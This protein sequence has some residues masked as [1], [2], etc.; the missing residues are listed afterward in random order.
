MP[1]AASKNNVAAIQVF[2]PRGILL[3]LDPTCSLEQV[4]PNLNP[5]LFDPL[6]QIENACRWVSGVMLTASNLPPKEHRIG[7]A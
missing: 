4:M 5:A 1:L 7:P 6:T 2:L 3:S